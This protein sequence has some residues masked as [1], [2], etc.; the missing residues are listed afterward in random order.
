LAEQELGKWGE[1]LV[2]KL[3]VEEQEESGNT[4]QKEQSL[5]WEVRVKSIK[6]KRLARGEAKNS[7][8]FQKPSPK[9]RSLLVVLACKGLSTR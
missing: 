3:L 5:R 4:N 8:P 2:L 1:F 6:T 9:G 7:P